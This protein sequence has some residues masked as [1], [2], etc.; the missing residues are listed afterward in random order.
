MMNS[1]V[2]T[3][4]LLN[5]PLLVRTTRRPALSGTDIDPALLAAELMRARRTVLPKRL[6]LPGPD[7]AQQHAMLEAATSAPDH[8]QLQPWRFVEVP[9]AARAALGQVFVQALLERDPQA[10]AEQCEQAREKA[11][12]SPWL[13]LLVVNGAGGDPAVDLLERTV[14]AG[15]AVQNLLLMATAHGFGSALTS[16]KALTSDPFRQL[17]ALTGGERA[18]CFV[19]VGTVLTHKPGRVRPCVAEVL[20]TL[21]P[22][23]P[24]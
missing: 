24:S 5:M 8:G 16:G 1:A 3:N 6:G 19:S 7:A 2:L 15:C 13:L 14:S 23:N 22:P 17:F 21:A 4:P 10:T 9:M 18:L 20:S 11:L 12:R